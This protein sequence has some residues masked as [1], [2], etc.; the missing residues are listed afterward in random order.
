[1][2]FLSS[3]P[4]GSVSGKSSKLSIFNSSPQFIFSHQLVLSGKNQ[5]HIIDN[6]HK[7]KGGFGSVNESKYKI[8]VTRE[9]KNKPYQARLIP[10]NDVVKIQKPSKDTPYPELL[11]RTAKEALRQKNMG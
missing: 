10:V 4:S 6:A 2:N 3:L 7:G 8:V 1:M 11:T 9:A 5:W